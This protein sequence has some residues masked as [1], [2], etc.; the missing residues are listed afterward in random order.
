[1]LPEMQRFTCVA[2][3]ANVISA[4]ENESACTVRRRAGSGVRILE[5]RDAPIVHKRTVFAHR[6][7]R[8]LAACEGGYGDFFAE[9][10]FAD[11]GALLIFLAGDGI[12]PYSFCAVFVLR[13]KTGGAI[14]GA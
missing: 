5:D 14:I 10:R 12:E 6:Y 1:M 8:T 13:V 4:A 3:R 2:G 11:C 9:K 7:H